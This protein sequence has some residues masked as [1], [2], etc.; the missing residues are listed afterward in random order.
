MNTTK[1]IY[2]KNIDTIK[3]EGRESN[4]PLAF[5]WYNENRIEPG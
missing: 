1:Q 5:K 4:N 3:F 2:F